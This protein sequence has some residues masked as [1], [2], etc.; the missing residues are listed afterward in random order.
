MDSKTT[1]E[2]AINAVRSSIALY[3]KLFNKKDE[4]KNSGFINISS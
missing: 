3:A 2:D 4:K 1:L